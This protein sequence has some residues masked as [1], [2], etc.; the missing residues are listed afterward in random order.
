MEGSVE[1]E[2]SRRRKRRGPCRIVQSKLSLH[3]S[4]E[5]KG[6]F[7]LEEDDAEG[8]EEYC[9]SQGKNKGKRMK[10]KVNVIPI[11][12]ASAQ[13]VVT[14]EMASRPN[15]CSDFFLKL[16][17]KKLRMKLHKEQQK[18]VSKYRQV[19][20]SGAG[21]G[22]CSLSKEED[23]NDVTCIDLTSDDSKGQHDK[24]GPVEIGFDAAECLKYQTSRAQSSCDLPLG[25]NTSVEDG[26][27]MPIGQ[28]TH[29]FFASWRT[30]KKS[31]E[32]PGYTGVGSKL[33]LAVH[34]NEIISGAPV[35]VF[36][37]PEDDLVPLDWGN[38]TFSET[39]VLNSS[40]SFGIDFSSPV[41]KDSV[42]PL[43]FGDS[44]TCSNSH[45]EV[46]SGKPIPLDQFSDQEKDVHSFSNGQG[47]VSLSPECS[48]SGYNSKDDLQDKL[49]HE[50]L[51]SHLSRCG[52][53]DSSLWTNKYQPEN[54]SEI[55]GNR[56]SI[57]LLR[58]WLDSWH[59]RGCQT[60][61]SFYDDDCFSTQDSEYNSSQN[62]SDGESMNGKA[63]LKNVFLVTGPVGCGKTSSVYACA[64]EKGFQVI[65]VSASDWR[66]GAN[67]KQKF[68][69]AMES[70]RLNK[71]S[72]EDCVSPLRKTLDFTSAE[73]P[74]SSNADSDDEV[75]DLTPSKVNQVVV[76]VK[77]EPLQ[78]LMRRNASSR[79]VNKSLIL[80]EDVDTIFDEDRGFIGT[81][82]QLAETT[83]RPIVLTC[84]SKDPGLPQHLDREVV[85]FRLPSLEELLPHLYMICSTEK[86]N[87]TP[88]LLERFISTCQC[89]IRKTI[90]LL[91]F[92][93]QGKEDIKEK[94]VRCLYNTL[95]LDLDAAHEFIKRMMPW[96]FPSQLSEKVEEEISKALHVAKENLS[97]VLPVTDE[98]EIY[99]RVK[100]DASEIGNN[101]TDSTKSRMSILS[102]N[103]SDDYNDISTQTGDFSDTTGTPVKFARRRVRQRACT[104]MSSESEDELYPKESP[105]ISDFQP[106][107]CNDQF[108]NV[109]DGPALQMPASTGPS[110]LICEYDS[111]QEKSCQKLFQSPQHK[112]S[113]RR[114]SPELLNA[115]CVPESSIVPETEISNRPIFP[116][117]SPSDH[118][119]SSA[120][121][122]QNL[123]DAVDRD[124]D[125]TLDST[126]NLE[127]MLDGNSEVES[128]S[129]NLNFEDSQNGNADSQTRRLMETHNTDSTMGSL[130]SEHCRFQSDAVIVNK[131][132]RTL[133][134]CH[135]E[136]KS[137]VTSEEKN[138]HQL[139]TLASGLTDLISAIDVMISGCES[140]QL[141]S[142]NL[143]ESL[144]PY[145]NVDDQCCNERQMDF[146]SIF[147]QHG[148]CF[149]AKD[150]A[151]MRS[152]GDDKNMVDL[153]RE[154]LS[155]S[156]N[157]ISFGKLVADEIASCQISCED[158]FLMRGVPG[159]KISA[160]SEVESE[161]YN[162]IHSVVPARSRL[163]LKG[164]A[165]HEYL[166][167]M[168]Q[169]SI[170]E[171]DRVKEDINMMKKRRRS[172]ASQH[173][174][175]LLLLIYLLKN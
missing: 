96:E 163:A 161:L 17:E 67:V 156:T 80:F 51:V 6:G 168:S 12:A 139:A 86:A 52:L 32:M 42:R 90:L 133:Q 115:C 87:I 74:I 78:T 73:L 172:R 53:L 60:S 28:R 37:T 124:Q 114:C 47:K 129:G 143:E 76:K 2:G 36:E 130:F 122:I 44:I 55:C 174:F 48:T 50:R 34:E 109:L 94:K 167:F 127:N 49:F 15:G 22:S 110:R 83:K 144:P 26:T 54:A 166:S 173:Y 100:F 3:G 142:Y 84:N 112:A 77:E 68:G 61:K 123:Y 64:K 149:F 93:C 116:C 89:D 171:N 57:R 134:C 157:I 29:P 121:P 62:D 170:S 69:E 137:Y 66:N 5:S 98:R 135:D 102:R 9:G 16:S 155:C 25:P 79:A 7:V 152:Y 81:L 27:C 107:N 38:W 45:G 63:F 113:P 24:Q 91:Q 39:S 153:A 33:C 21:R 82:I 125:V 146:A 40:S 154:M 43:Q 145:D 159:C 14:S 117:V 147:A 160:R 65:E 175:L 97:Y 126:K 136:L 111:S 132:W 138:A 71:R 119:L 70:H 101:E 99:L 105:V 131:T 162:T 118:I 140:E 56:E 75:I 158:R 150:S 20:D 88:R 148:L 8:G 10:K 35:H 108:P 72:H 18:M 92:W 120:N 58:E 11:K 169:I 31:Q 30:T 4:Q 103:C 46:V 141:V 59:E 128:I 151:M 106:C 95:P 23:G 1:E 165:F 104:I 13:D 85:N 19:V 41:F 164:P